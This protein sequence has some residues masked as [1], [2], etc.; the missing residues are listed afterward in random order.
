[1]PSTHYDATRCWK[2]SGERFP[3]YIILHTRPTTAHHISMLA[4]S[5]SCPRRDHSKG[6]PL[7]SLE[8]CLTI[9]PLFVSLTSELKIGF[10]DDITMEGRKDIVVNDIIY[11]KDKTDKYGLVLNAAKCEVVYEDPLASHDDNMLKDF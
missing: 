8:F 9:Q 2:T 11:I 6:D 7:S 10:L 3:K 1:M 5:P 4:T